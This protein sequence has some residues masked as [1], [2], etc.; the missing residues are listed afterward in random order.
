[1]CGEFAMLVVKRPEYVV[2]GTGKGGV[3]PLVLVH[4]CMI[5]ALTHLPQ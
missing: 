3:M 4:V 1:M 2:S 5:K